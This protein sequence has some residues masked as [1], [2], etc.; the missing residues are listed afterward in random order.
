MNCIKKV[1]KYRMGCC[2]STAQVAPSKSVALQLQVIT[3]VQIYRSDAPGVQVQPNKQVHDPNEKPVSNNKNSP[4]LNLESVKASNQEVSQSSQ[5]PQEEDMAQQKASV[6]AIGTARNL[7]GGSSN[8]EEGGFDAH[9]K[10]D[11]EECGINSKPEMPS[12]GDILYKEDSNNKLQDES[13]KHLASVNALSQSNF[14]Q[15]VDI[16]NQTFR[17]SIQPPKILQVPKST[18]DLMLQNQLGNIMECESILEA[19]SYRGEEEH[20]KSVRKSISSKMHH[21]G[22]FSLG[23]SKKSLLKEYSEKMAH[24]NEGVL[25]KKEIKS[26]SN[27]RMAAQEASFDSNMEEYLPNANPERQSQAAQEPSLNKENATGANDVV[28][29][30]TLVPKSRQACAGDS[31]QTPIQKMIISK[32]EL[33]KITHRRSLT[34]EKDPSIRPHINVIASHESIL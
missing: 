20:L 3:P 5:N 32:E 24:F 9:A 12:I 27:Q 8:F 6:K 2:Q 26:P 19:S 18:T 10:E 14:Q 4:N 13:T 7:E 28:E 30:V 16:N 34:I 11:S 25:R 22:S 31:K 15:S 29:N 33:S 23:I 17:S 1:V 21:L